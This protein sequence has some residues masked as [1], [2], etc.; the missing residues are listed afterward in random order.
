MRPLGVET[1]GD[2]LPKI[3]GC[4]LILLA[5]KVSGKLWWRVAR[6]AAVASP[7]WRI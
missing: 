3:V 5:G 7:G 1:S 4:V 2:I 6:L